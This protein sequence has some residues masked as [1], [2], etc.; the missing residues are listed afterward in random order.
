MKFGL[1]LVVVGL[2]AVAAH[3]A[4]GARGGGSTRRSVTGKGRPTM[5]M[6]VEEGTGVPAAVAP[7][8]PAEVAVVPVPAPAVTVATL[9]S[10]STGV[11]AAAGL[12]AAAMPGSAAA[13]APTVQR[14]PVTRRRARA[15]ESSSLSPSTQSAPDPNAWFDTDLPPF[16]QRDASGNRD[17]GFWWRRVRKNWRR[18]IFNRNG[19]FN[20]D[21]LRFLACTVNQET[22]D[23][24]T[25]DALSRVV[26][27]RMN[28]A[29]GM[30]EQ[31]IQ[32]EREKFER[33][34]VGRSG[35]KSKDVEK[36]WSSMERAI[37]A[38]WRELLDSMRRQFEDN[39]RRSW[40]T[41]RTLP[42]AALGAAGIAAGSDNGED[43]DEED[44]DEDDAEEWDGS[45]E[46][47]GEDDGSDKDDGGGKK[48]KK[49]DDSDWE[50]DGGGKQQ[51]K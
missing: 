29:E 30:L 41:M 7:A 10:T 26:L 9:P 47:D 38:N 31:A 20:T 14:T 44:D 50:D 22:F 21:F 12:P 42:L 11:P 48:R 27:T 51:A 17:A 34:W 36:A 49:G 8:V 6:D 18:Y 16:C 4:P 28:R 3:A 19:E 40:R 37:R 2:L 24:I 35:V 43:D 5:D 25:E 39:A 1:K 32:A 45:G 33:D 23:M 46:E 15:D 13:A